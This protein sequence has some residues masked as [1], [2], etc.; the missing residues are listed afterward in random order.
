MSIINQYV[1]FEGYISIL[2]VIIFVIY[3]LIFLRGRLLKKVLVPIALIN[4]VLVINLFIGIFFTFAFGN[5]VNIFLQESHGLRLLALFLT[6]FL[7]FMVCIFI[8]KLDKNENSELSTTEMMA[9]IGVFIITMI[10]GISAFELEFERINKDTLIIILII[11]IVFINVYIIYMVKLISVKN[12][13]KIEV[14]I[15][16]TQANVQK[17]IIEDAGNI[18]KEI[19]RFKHDVK[20]HFVGIL[21]LMEES[22]TDEAISYLKNLL[23]EYDTHIFDYIHISNAVVNAILNFKIGKC[24]RFNIDLKIEIDSEIDFG[25]FSETDLCI[26]ISNIFDNAIEAC[27]KSK[28]PR[29]VISISNSNGYL[30]ITLKNSISESVLKNN[31]LLKTT[32]SDSEKHGI[33]IMSIRKIVHK[34][35]GILDFSEVNGYFITDAWLKTP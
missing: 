21:T 33:D 5:S 30:C 8:L 31:S 9:A 1:I 15:L 28:H 29:I 18:S 34:Y 7:F 16:Q 6:K 11:G 26:L 12:A 17:S 32:K 23:K 10:M 27:V 4:A 2:T 13:K 19:K 3:N 24:R 20:H 25:K 22:K 35:D 14:T